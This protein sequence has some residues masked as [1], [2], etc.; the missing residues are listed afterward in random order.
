MAL[1]IQRN[2]QSPEQYITQHLSNPERYPL[3]D[4]QQELFERVKAAWGYLTD[5]GLSREQTAR[6]VAEQFGVSVETARKNVTATISIYGLN[7][8]AEKEGMRMIVY[9]M[10]SKTFQLAAKREDLKTMAACQKNLIKV[11]GLDRDDPDTPNFEKLEQNNNYI[12][13][14]PADQMAHLYNML[15]APGSIDLNKANY[16]EYEELAK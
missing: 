6:K 10:I 12:I 5:K 1:P 7:S 16:D 11:F 8:R 3:T 9:E 14:V 2:K 13:N 4:K 15:S